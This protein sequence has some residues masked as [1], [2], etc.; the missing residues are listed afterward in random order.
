MSTAVTP[1]MPA[2]AGAQAA[3]PAPACDRLN[4][5]RWNGRYYVLQR[6]AQAMRRVA[7]D[8]VAPSP[9]RV[10][11]DLGC[12]DTPYRALLAPLVGR[13]LGVDL[14]GNPA[15]DMCLRADGSAPLPDASA[16]I[17]L[18][19]QVLEHVADP[20]A[21]LDECRRLLRPGGRL[22]LSTHGVWKYHPHP[23]DFWRWTSA[24]LVR[25]I[26]S[27]GFQI[28]HVQ[29]LLGPAACGLLLLQDALVVKLPRPLRR[30]AAAAFQPLLALADR[31][32]TQDQR[33]ADAA[34]YLLVARMN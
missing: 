21:Y 2:P 4:P 15:A 27:A 25:T 26:E 22:I 3:R 23:D 28:V 10:L 13:Y 18:S 1:T 33:D 7:D 14:P 20:R 5:S 16:D 24:G 29:G 6:L 17:V 11:V 19:T 34:V 32:H 31:L 8:H 9:A 12:G 30:F